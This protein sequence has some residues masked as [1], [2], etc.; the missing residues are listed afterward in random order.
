M[1]QEALHLMKYHN[2]HFPVAGS[3][4]LLTF[5]LAAACGCASHDQD[6]Q[7]TAPAAGPSAAPGAHVAIEQQ[8]Q[9][10][11]TS[12]AAHAGVAPPPPVAPKASAQ[13]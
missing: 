6:A 4:A 11:A 13:P 5:S 3:I 8:E 7:S 2:H 12:R 1:R 10:D 9:S